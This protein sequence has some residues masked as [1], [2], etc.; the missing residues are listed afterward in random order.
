MR[1]SERLTE[2]RR[3]VLLQGLGEAQAHQL[4]DSVLKK[5][6]AFVGHNVSTD[7]VRGDL[8]WL[9]EHG[10]VRVSKLAV[11]SG[12]LW[13]VHLT[14]AGREVLEGRTYPGI[15]PIEPR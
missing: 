14:G 7:V 13:V 15:A 3:L 9:D 12:E 6:L 1:F 8:M 4:N 11:A 5:A 2:D 10:M